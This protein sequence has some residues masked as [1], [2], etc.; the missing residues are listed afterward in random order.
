MGEIIDIT[1]AMYVI[2][3]RISYKQHRSVENLIKD[4]YKILDQHSLIIFNKKL[5][6]LKIMQVHYLRQ[7]LDLKLL[8]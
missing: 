7:E 5:F 1:S 3:V 4:A 2:I 6:G 8:L